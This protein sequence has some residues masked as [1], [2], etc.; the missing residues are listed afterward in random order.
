MSQIFFSF[1]GGGGRGAG[2]A[3]LPTVTQQLN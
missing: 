2:S 1:V 3:D